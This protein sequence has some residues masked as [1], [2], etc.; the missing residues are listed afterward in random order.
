MV[1]VLHSVLIKLAGYWRTSFRS[2]R[3]LSAV[4]CACYERGRDTLLRRVEAY[5]EL[6]ELAVEERRHQLAKQR[7]NDVIELIWKI[8]G[9]K[10]P[11]LRRQAKAII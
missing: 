6:E 3:R 9:I 8:E 10:D 5:T 1:A 11:Q 7:A 2:W 4:L